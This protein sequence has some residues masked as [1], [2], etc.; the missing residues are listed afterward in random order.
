VDAGEGRLCGIDP[1]GTLWCWGW[2]NHMLDPDPP[3]GTWDRLS[4]GAHHACARRADGSI[5]CWGYEESERRMGPLALVPG[6]RATAGDAAALGLAP[7]DVVEIAAGGRH[8]CLATQGGAV[9]C[10]GDDRHGQTAAPPIS[11][12][13]LAAGLDLT[14]GLDEASL[15]VCWGLGLHGQ[16][17]APAV[18]LRDLAVGRALACGLDGAGTVVCWGRPDGPLDGVHPEGGAWD[19]IDI[20]ATWLGEERLCARRGPETTCVAWNQPAS[21][22]PMGLTALALG[23]RHACGLDGAGQPTCWAADLVGLG[24]VPRPTFSWP[25]R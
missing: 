18:A 7:G 20:G 10:I 11:L 15:P 12:H 4:V 3:E 19:E 13:G 14:C 8:T 6:A 1:S 22:P 5:A 16:T 24:P 23:G 25:R 17:E 21:Q 9:T 2:R